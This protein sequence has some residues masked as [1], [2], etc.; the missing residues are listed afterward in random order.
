MSMILDVL[1]IATLAICVFLYTKRGFIRGVMGLCGCLIAMIA[2][3]L[4]K[5]IL[6]PFL[7]ATLKKW[8]DGSD[9]K[10]LSSLLGVGMTAEV[11]AS[12]IAFV[13]LFVL[14]MAIVKIAT[15]LIDRFCKLPILK[16]ANKLMGFVLGTVIGLLYA[17]IL[18]LLLFSF[19]ELL[20]VSLGWLSEDAFEGSVVARWMFDHNLFRLLM[21]LG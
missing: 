16:Q 7:E 14:Y 21:G 19:S 2:A 15:Y 18:S 4:T 6:Q 13:L 9:Q 17:Q 1:V 20:V 10:G 5:P 11:I 12:A 3:V 8:L